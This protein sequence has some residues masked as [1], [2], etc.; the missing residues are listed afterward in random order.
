MSISFAFMSNFI[1]GALKLKG[2]GEVSHA[3]QASGNIVHV[4]VGGENLEVV[5]K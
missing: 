4:E 1:L 3:G 5:G 2:L